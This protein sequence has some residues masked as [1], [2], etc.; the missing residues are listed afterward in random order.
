VTTGTG[1]GRIGLVSLADGRIVYIAPTG[2]HLALWQ[3]NAA[4]GQPK[5]LTTEPSFLE[6]VAAPPDGRYFVLSSNRAR[7]SHLFR[8]ERD[9]ANLRQLTQGESFEIDSDCSPD[10]RWIVY[11]SL[12]IVPDKIEKYQL[13]KIPAEGGVPIRLTDSKADE[14]RFSPDGKWISYVHWEEPVR[15]KL[16]IISADGGAPVKTF[17]ALDSAVLNAGCRWTPDGQ[18]LTYIVTN[19]GVSNIWAQPLNGSPPYPL[20]NFNSGE[21]YNYDFAPDGQRLFL[22]RGYPIRDALLIRNF[23]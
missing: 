4:G 5:P 7:H 15:Y 17:N 1:E 9:G 2:D 19:K 12:P 21:I 10:G 18:A 8:V 14:P 6:S 20:T 22:A 11:A 13:W 16:V 3:V 23:R